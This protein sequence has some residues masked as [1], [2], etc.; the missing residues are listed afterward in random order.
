MAVFGE[1]ACLSPAL[2]FLPEAWDGPGGDSAHILEPG[3][4]PS[5]A[6]G[7]QGLICASET[8]MLSCLSE[9]GKCRVSSLESNLLVEL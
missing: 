4:A 3:A 8:V 1:T 6:Q 9:P 7:T 2:L 5:P